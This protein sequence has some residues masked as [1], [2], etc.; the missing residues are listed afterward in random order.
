MK[1]DKPSS[2]TGR[3]FDNPFLEKIT[4]TR[5]VVPI[6]LFFIISGGLLFWGYSREF[7]AIST[8]IEMFLMGWLVF[9]LIEYA[10]HRYVFHMETNT[11]RRVEIQYKVHGIHHDYPKDKERLAMPPVLSLPISLILYF[12]FNA[13]MGSA[14]FGFLPGFLVGYALYL[15]VHYAVHAYQP[16][17]N[18]LKVL[19]INHGIHHYKD[20]ERAFGVS[21]PLWDYVFRT[22]PKRKQE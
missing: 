20:H 4:R 10:V 15:F 19:W 6:T 13:L 7:L 16:P 2:A 1:L 17:K 21:T 12:I 11:I 5:T 18:F 8:L 14:V 3:L 9:S 22:M